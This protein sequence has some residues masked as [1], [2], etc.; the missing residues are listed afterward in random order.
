MFPVLMYV[1]PLKTRRF[2]LGESLADFI[3][4][5]HPT[6][7][8]RSI[9][10][11]ASKIVALSQKRWI[12]R[13]FNETDV[14]QVSQWYAKTPYAYLTLVDGHWCPNA[15]MDAS[16][17]S[18]GSVL[19]PIDLV[20][21]LQLLYVRLKQTFV[22]KE[23]GLVVSDSR[24][25]P[26][27]QGVTAVSLAH[28][29]FR[30]LRDYRGASDLDGRPLRM[31]T[32]NVADALATSASLLMGEGSEQQPLA[33]IEDAPIVFT[34]ECSQEELFIAPSDDLFAPLYQHLPG[35]PAV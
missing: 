6:L 24:V 15:G 28:A 4:E 33:L 14:A 21:E 1:N 7:P 9:L 34:N 27:R 13:E 17:A 3:L 10:V 31:T 22:C 23:F 8:E 19:W 12:E 26:L 2:C 29:G 35:F 18:G 5:H 25:F 20:D 16:N 32:V 11:I 30:A